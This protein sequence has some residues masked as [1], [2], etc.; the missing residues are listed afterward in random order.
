MD[1]LSRRKG[2]TLLVCARRE[3]MQTSV[4]GGYALITVGQLANVC[5]ARKENRITFLALRTWLAAHEQR[6]KRCTARGRVRFTLSE[7]A[8]LV[9]SPR[10]SRL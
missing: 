5:A 4:D 1:F 3:H 8:R 7:L 9:R 6:A 2:G 10:V